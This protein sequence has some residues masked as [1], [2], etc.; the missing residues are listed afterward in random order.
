MRRVI[1]I[2]LVA[3][4]LASGSALA[5]TRILPAESVGAQDVPQV[6]L[7]SADQSGVDLLLE[8]PALSM[9][10]LTVDG[11]QFHSVA[12]PGGGLEGAIGAPGIPTFTRLV[13]IPAESGVTVTATPMDEE[14]IPGVMLIDRKSVV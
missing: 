11:Q 14:D 6:Q 4:F 3:L 13:A 9:E 1:V 8:L 2:G 12:V 10:T 5:T 7:L